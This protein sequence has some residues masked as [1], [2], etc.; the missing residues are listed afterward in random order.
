MDPV[1]ISCA[2]LLAV[3][4]DTVKCDGVNLRP[5]GDGAPYVSGFDAPDLGWRADCPAEHRRAIRA[6][7]RMSEMLQTPGLVV[8]GSGQSDVYGRP[9]VW[10]AL[11]GGRTVG[12]VLIEEGLAREWRPSTAA[13]WSLRSGAA[14]PRS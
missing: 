12:S 11:P 10:L 9:L 1:I 7:A 13:T 3:D 4:G 6:L 5:M 2:V 14:R 8:L